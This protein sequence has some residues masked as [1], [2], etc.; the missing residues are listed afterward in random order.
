MALKFC[1][2]PGK[3]TNKNKAGI[4]KLNAVLLRNNSFPVVP[5]FG[6]RALSLRKVHH[7][8]AFRTKAY[9]ISLQTTSFVI[10]DSY[11]IR[12][13]GGESQGHRF[14]AGVTNYENGKTIEANTIKPRIATFSKISSLKPI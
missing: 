7:H 13:R 4:V 6:M 12:T 11:S 5:V 3:P 14:A 1:F 8:V 9:V 2:Q 10:L